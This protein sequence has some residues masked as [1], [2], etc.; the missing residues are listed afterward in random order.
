MK[1]PY[2]INLQ[3]FAQEKTEKAT[4]KKREESRKKGQVAKSTEVNTA[5]I[6]LFVFISLFFLGTWMGT[7]LLSIYRKSFLEYFFWEFLDSQS[8]YH[9][10]SSIN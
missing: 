9:L 10:Y 1:Y 2:P 8:T 3:F 7:I 4:P 5:F 6:M